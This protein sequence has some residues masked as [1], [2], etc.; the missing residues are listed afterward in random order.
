MTLKTPLSSR[1][2]RPSKVR[3]VGSAQKLAQIPIMKHLY[4]FLLLMFMTLAAGTPQVVLAQNLGQILS[5]ILI[6]DREKLFA[7]S[8]FGQSIMAQLN[9]ISAGLEAETREI[10]TNLEAEELNLSMARST[11]P[12]E[13]FRALADAFDIKVQQL[14]QSRS[15]AEEQQLLDIEKARIVF[16]EQVN[17]ILATL[18]QEA[19]AIVLMERRDVVISANSI[20]IT[21]KAISR[22]DALFARGAVPAAGDPAES[23]Q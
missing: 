17:P 6:I 20:D 8:A 5:P 4:T 15:A 9:D 21:T 14:R 3:K 22:I 12:A 11:L 10:V 2:H 19:G 1:S 13:E 16:L 18:M 7:E 23:T